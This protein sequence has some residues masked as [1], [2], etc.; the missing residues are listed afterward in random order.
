MSAAKELF[1]NTT[2]AAT[3]TAKDLVKQIKRIHRATMKTTSTATTAFKR[4][5]AH[6]VIGRPFLVVTQDFVGFADFL[7][8]IFGRFVVGIF[9]RMKLHGLLAIS[10]LD[11]IR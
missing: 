10:L 11:F 5:M 7:E 8:F 4:G 1:K 3:T 9:V 2:T 6:L